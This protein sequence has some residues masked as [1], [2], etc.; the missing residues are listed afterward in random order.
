VGEERHCCCWHP[1]QPVPEVAVLVT[2]LCHLMK[3]EP[4]V[5]L[6]GVARQAGSPCLPAPVVGVQESKGIAPLDQV[7]V[8][9]EE[10]EGRG[11]ED[12][13]RRLLV[14]V[15]EPERKGV[16]VRKSIPHIYRMMAAGERAEKAKAFV[17]RWCFPAEGVMEG[18]GLGTEGLL[19]GETNSPL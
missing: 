19:L 5:E 15:A 11:E 8:E 1:Q 17:C 2:R 9:G 12:C 6:E 16:V 4:A 10:V 14:E 3:W 7:E 18:T 13:C